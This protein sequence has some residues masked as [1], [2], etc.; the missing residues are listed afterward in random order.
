MVFEHIIIIN[1]VSEYNYIGPKRQNF[2]LILYL[3]SAKT[4]SV[5]FFMN[6][7]T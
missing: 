1:I 2:R 3:L 5:L 6:Y 7:V 4:H